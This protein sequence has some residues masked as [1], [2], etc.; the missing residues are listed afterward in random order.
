VLESRQLAELPLP[1]PDEQLVAQKVLGVCMHQVWT[2]SIEKYAQFASC[3][4]CGERLFLSGNWAPEI[5]DA[6]VCEMWLKQL[7]RCASDE[8]AADAVRRK[9]EEQGWSVRIIQ[10]SSM[11]ACVL[12]KDD[13]RFVSSAHERRAAAISEAAAKAAAAFF[14]S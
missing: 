4:R 11:T 13:A 3:V 5:G 8:A 2:R 7:P 12:R 9:L 6:A 14:A 10:S 1:T